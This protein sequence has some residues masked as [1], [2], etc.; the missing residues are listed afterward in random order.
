MPTFE[1]V[2]DIGELVGNAL[3]IERKNPV[4]DMIS[5]SLVSLIE[6]A[7]FGCRLERSDDYPRGIRT[8]I[9]RLPIHEVGL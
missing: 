6:F 9:E 7:G 5:A 1:I 4:D 3:G 8:Q 2:Q